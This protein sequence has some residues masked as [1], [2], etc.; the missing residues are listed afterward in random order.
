[1]KRGL[2]LFEQ[3]NRLGEYLL[4]HI[5]RSSYMGVFNTVH[6]HVTRLVMEMEMG[7]S[8]LRLVGW[9]SSLTCTNFFLR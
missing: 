1:M 6:A 7:M 8:T 5:T 9:R 4:K 2:N 3:I